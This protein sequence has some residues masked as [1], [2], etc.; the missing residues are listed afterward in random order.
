MNR[1]PRRIDGDKHCLGGCGCTL[2][3]WFY[4]CKACEPPGWDRYNPDTAAIL[5]R[6]KLEEKSSGVRKPRSLR[7]AKEQMRYYKDRGLPVPDV[8]LDKLGQS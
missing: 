5:G 3:D 6:D 2:L 7:Q 1:P 8:V 4:F